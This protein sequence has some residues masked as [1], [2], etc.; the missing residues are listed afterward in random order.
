[1][2][3]SPRDSAVGTKKN[4]QEIAKKSA[5]LLRT[6]YLPDS[7]LNRCLQLFSLSICRGVRRGRRNCVA[8]ENMHEGNRSMKNTRKYDLEGSMMIIIISLD[9]H[10]ISLSWVARDGLTN[11]RMSV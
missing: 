4:K 3:T 11:S 1:V 5:I 2:A 10:G 7:S 9:Q 8:V 6:G